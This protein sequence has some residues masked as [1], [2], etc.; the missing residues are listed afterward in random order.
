[1]VQAG[2]KSLYEA[3]QQLEEQLAEAQHAQQE[4]EKNNR[5][6]AQQL[7]QAHSSAAVSQPADLQRIQDLSQ[8]VCLCNTGSWRCHMANTSCQRH[9]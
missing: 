1:M 6:L 5:Q 3:K 7:E 4:Q 9:Y 2:A 8:Q